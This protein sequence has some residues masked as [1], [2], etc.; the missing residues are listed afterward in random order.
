MQ[1][2]TILGSTGT[3]GAQTL[4]VIARHPQ[5]YQVFALTANTNVSVLLKQCLDFKPKYAVLLD[6]AAAAY[7]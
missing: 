5:R 7:C 6:A 2:V 3:I 1:N 4:D